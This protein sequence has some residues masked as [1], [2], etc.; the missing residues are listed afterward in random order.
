MKAPDK[1]YVTVHHPISE[2]YT[3]IIGFTE[4]ENSKDAEYIRKEALMEWAKDKLP[5]E[6]T[7][8]GFMG[9]YIAAYKELIDKL[10]EM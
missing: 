9:G 6:S 3:E 4:R 5:V 2:E 10:N 8:Y 7:V 1:I